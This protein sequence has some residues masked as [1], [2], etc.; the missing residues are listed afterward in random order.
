MHIVQVGLRVIL[1][2]LPRR[3]GGKQKTTY[4]SLENR[5]LGNS[6]PATAAKPWKNTKPQMI[7]QL[8]D[9]L[10]F[11]EEVPSGRDLRGSAFSGAV[12]LNLRETDFSY[13]PT[14]G[15]FTNCDLYRAKL[16]H[17]RGS[18]HEITG[19]LIE[20]S[21]IAA[22]LNKTWLNQSRF[23]NC[24]FN[25]A[26]LKSAN[27]N[28][29]DF[30]GSSF[31]DAD[32]GWADFQYCDLRACDFRGANLKGIMLREVKLDK[33][34]DFRGANLQDIVH[35]DQYDIYG[36]LVIRG[37]DW[38]QATYDETTLLGTDPIAFDLQV[39]P[40]RKKTNS[41]EF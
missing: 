35:E 2:F 4:R 37:T 3:V 34:T 19:K 13:S 33:T 31:K 28:H 30:R 11:R 22:E 20:T 32:C 10:P 9:G 21:F 40:V 24:I 39:I 36:K 14:I 6:E 16:D 27:L 18:V 7:F 8:L 29:S 41:S 15:G 5:A 26:N 38:R 1:S 23:R 12:N 25:R 17:I